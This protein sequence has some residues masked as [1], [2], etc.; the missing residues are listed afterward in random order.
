[1]I[2]KGSERKRKGGEGSTEELIVEKEGA[3]EKTKREGDG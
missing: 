1:L 2:I 3:V